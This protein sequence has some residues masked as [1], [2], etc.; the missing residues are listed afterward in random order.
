M[1]VL[2]L[3]FFF[4]F[5][6]PI[7][8][9]VFLIAVYKIEELHEKKVPGQEEQEDR[10]YPTIKFNT[11]SRGNISVKQWINTHGE[12]LTA[13]F[14]F[15]IAD[16]PGEDAFIEELTEALMLYGYTYVWVDRKDK[17]VKAHEGGKRKNDKTNV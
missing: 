6:F 17:C 1:L 10:V 12:N 4:L 11:K 14:S 3:V 16:L 8:R 9:A 7:I 5:V 13:D 15:A 2:F